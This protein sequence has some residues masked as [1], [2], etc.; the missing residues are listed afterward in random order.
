[1]IVFPLIRSVR[2]KA[3]MRKVGAVRGVLSSVLGEVRGT[4]EIRNKRTNVAELI[5]ILR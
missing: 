3:A 4:L 2:L 1:M 5:E